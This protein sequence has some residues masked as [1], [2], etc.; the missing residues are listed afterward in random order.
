MDEK[1]VIAILQRGWV[2][3]GKLTKDGNE[4]ILTNAQNIRR[5]GTSNGLGEL[6]E[7]GPLKETKLDKV[8]TV[9]FHELTTV[10]LIECDQDV[11]SKEL[12]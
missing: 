3:V 12:E 10:A 8:G 5:W 11:W 7:K 1:I 9:K 2:F 4:C 6:A